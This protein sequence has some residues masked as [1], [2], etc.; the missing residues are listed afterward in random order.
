MSTTE[1]QNF[2]T[3]QDFSSL[4]KFKPKSEKEIAEFI[5]FCHLKNIPIEVIGS[6]SK[7]NIGRNFWC[8]SKIKSILDSK[9]RKNAGK[10][11]PPYG[12]YLKKVNY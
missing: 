9:D 2:Q 11:A 5:K 3:S 6:G 10:T 1:K 4:S 12:L 7:V 8:V